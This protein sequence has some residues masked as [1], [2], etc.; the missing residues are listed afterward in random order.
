MTHF[1]ITLARSHFDFEYFEV[2]GSP[3]LPELW[4]PFQFLNKRFYWR[5]SFEEFVCNLGLA[6]IILAYATP[7]LAILLLVLYWSDS[8][9]FGL[10]GH[11]V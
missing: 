6:F 8:T 10:A 5:W 11:C 9:T 7:W 3:P 1:T 2:F 4:A